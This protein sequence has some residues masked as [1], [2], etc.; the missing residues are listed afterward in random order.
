[1]MW[2]IA[3]FLGLALSLF[4][5][6]HT[7]R[8]QKKNDKGMPQ[9]IEESIHM[10][11]KCN[12]ELLFVTDLDKDFFENDLVLNSLYS[13]NERK[14]KIHII[15]D[16]R[17]QLKEHK[18]V[19]KM[20]RKGI[21]QVKR[22]RKELKTHYWICDGLHTRLDSHEF[23]KFDEDKVTG[24]FYFNFPQLAY[25]LRNKFNIQWARL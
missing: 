23:G 1:M 14:V 17:V 6:Y 20:I 3:V 10:F 13:A 4:V 9:K 7:Y 11:N 24:K 22:S 8:N 12:D 21:I 16:P 18:F 15:Y 5:T 19:I 2:I 25:K